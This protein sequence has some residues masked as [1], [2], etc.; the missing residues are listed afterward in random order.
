M[1]PVAPSIFPV[2]AGLHYLLHLR[3]SL[4]TPARPR[5]F[6]PWRAIPRRVSHGPP[7]DVVKFLPGR[8]ITPNVVNPTSKR[9]LQKPIEESHDVPEVLICVVAQPLEIVGKG[10]QFPPSGG[11]RRNHV[12][13]R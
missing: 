3:K 11:A 7:D 6:P 2:V 10:C 4:R 13:P 9:S 12:V 8:R 5:R 1:K